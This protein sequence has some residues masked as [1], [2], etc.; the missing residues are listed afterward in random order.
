VT[1]S[2][3]SAL[4]SPSWSLCVCTPWTGAR[5]CRLT[6]CLLAASQVI[7][8]ALG[9]FGSWLELRSSLSSPVQDGAEQQHS[10]CCLRYA[11]VLFCAKPIITQAMLLV[12]Y[13][14]ALFVAAVLQMYQS[15]AVSAAAPQQHASTRPLPQA[16]QRSSSNSSSSASGN[17]KCM[18]WTPTTTGA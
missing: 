4:Q 16:Q 9:V 18:A 14:Y 15:L 2:G 6:W 3:F 11:T 5:A 10:F 17:T 13:D 12:L 7:V 1:F 8:V